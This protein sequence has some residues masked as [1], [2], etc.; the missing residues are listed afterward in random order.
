MFVQVIQGRVSDA[1]QETG[2][3]ASQV[4]AAAGE[5]S[6]NGEVLRTQVGAFLAEVR[7]A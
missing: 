4:L 2:A 5:L 7:A 3:A 1:A 6:Q